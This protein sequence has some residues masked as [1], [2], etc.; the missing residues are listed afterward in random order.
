MKKYNITLGLLLLNIFLA[1][2]GIGLIIP[3][4]P[5]LINELGLRELPL[6]ISLQLLQS[7][8]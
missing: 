8:N 3:V 6:V 2:L 4:M 5:S 1:F 7:P